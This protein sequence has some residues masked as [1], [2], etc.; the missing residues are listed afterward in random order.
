MFWVVSVAPIWLTAQNNPADDYT[1]LRMELSVRLA[2]APSAEVRALVDSAESYASKKDY[3]LAV[4]F[5]EE[6]RD[7]LR[8]LLPIPKK[9]PVKADSNPLQAD[10]PRPYQLSVVSGIDFNRQEF[11]LG[12]SQSDSVLTDQI[13]KPYV[14]LEMTWASGSFSLSDNVRYDQENLDNNLTVNLNK[15]M[16]AH[17]LN[18]RAAYLYNRNAVYPDLSFNELLS[19]VSWQ[20][21]NDTWQIRFQNLSRVKMY[22]RPV[23]TVPDYLR[24]TFSATLGYYPGAFS[25]INI[26]YTLDRNESKDTDNNDFFNQQGVLDWRRQLGEWGDI[27][28]S[29]QGEWNQY[30]YLLGDSLL[31]NRAT[32]GYLPARFTLRLGARFALQLSAG[33]RIKTYQYKTEQEPDYTLLNAE[34]EL[35]WQWDSGASL[36]IGLVWEQRKHKVAPG[37]DSV[38]VIQQDYKDRGVLLSLDYSRPD[39]AMISATLKYSARRYPFAESAA[40]FSLYAN[41][42]VWSALLFARWPVTKHFSVNAVAMYDNDKDLDS[43]FNDS[44]SSFYTFE[45]KYDF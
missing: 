14:G 37:L 21:L 39:G 20:F 28:L 13:S 3:D 5:L 44:K 42:N 29:P 6:A 27:Q 26:Y 40:N 10:L 18:L 2:Y 35:A 34:P 4:I 22:A 19:D 31:N 43:A 1:M 11:E 7:Q 8:D 36:G 38:Y 9:N 33:W 45:L 17:R 30:A 32:V 41:K 25:G 24:N 12:Y 23:A 16:G 15:Q